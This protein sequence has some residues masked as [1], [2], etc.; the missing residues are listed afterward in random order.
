MKLY[1]LSNK[2]KFCT[3]SKN[4][5]TSDIYS[6]SPASTYCYNI[7]Q[8]KQTC[9]HHCCARKNKNLRK[10]RLTLFHCNKLANNSTTLR[11]VF[12]VI[13]FNVSTIDMYRYTQTICKQ[14]TNTRSRVTVESRMHSKY[15]RPRARNRQYFIRSQG[16]ITIS[17]VFRW[18]SRNCKPVG[19]RNFTV[20]FF[21]LFQ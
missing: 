7:E 18:N 9:A 1:Q 5:I 20:E 10:R 6:L 8:V 19:L 12:R 11:N 17:M 15:S 16:P 4:D 21:T 13:I 3:I 14:L 2:V